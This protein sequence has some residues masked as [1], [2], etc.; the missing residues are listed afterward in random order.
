M[1]RCQICGMDYTKE[2]EQ[3]TYVEGEKYYLCKGCAVDVKDRPEEM[4][5]KLEEAKRATSREEE[6]RVHATSGVTPPSRVE[7]PSKETGGRPDVVR[8]SEMGKE[9]NMPTQRV[10]RHVVEKERTPDLE[11]QY[12]SG[13]GYIPPEG[14]GSPETRRA[15]GFE[16]SSTMPPGSKGMA[17]VRREYIEEPGTGPVCDACGRK[18]SDRCETI[19]YAGQ[20][21]RVCGE[22]IPPTKENPS[23]FLAGKK[24]TE[25][26]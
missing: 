18:H 21:F 3:S 1:V 26:Q 20:D 8:P 13:R 4:R 17:G 2:G 15:V 9:T 10:E 24:G 11:K 5:R 12:E 19:N 22:C 7:M 6:S 23:D 14:A 16:P 25:P